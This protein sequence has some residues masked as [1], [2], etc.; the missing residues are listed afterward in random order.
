MY[1][2]HNKNKVALMILNSLT[3]SREEFAKG[4]GWEI[5]PE[6]ACKG[7]FCVTLSRQYSDDLDVEQLAEEIGLPLIQAAGI[8]LWSLGPESHGNRALL[9]AQ[10]ADLELPDLS[11]ELFKLGSLRGQKVLLYAWAPY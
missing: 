1:P 2:T 9:S 7:D 8:P 10:A 5:K 11:G 6:G 3:L 4:T